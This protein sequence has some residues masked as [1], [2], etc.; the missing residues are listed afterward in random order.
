MNLIRNLDLNALQNEE[1]F[2]IQTDFK[3]EVIKA[4][5]ESLSIG[6]L[7]AAYLLLYADEDAAT[8]LIK[9]SSFT[10]LVAN[11]DFRRDMVSTGLRSLVKVFTNHFD[12]AKQQ[13]AKNM[14]VVFE[15]YG[16]IIDMPYKKQTGATTNLLNELNTNHAAG[17]SLFHLDEY[18]AQLAIENT[19]VNDLMSDRFDEAAAKPL[20]RM[21]EV[22]AEIDVVYKKIIERINAGIIFNGPAAYEGFVRKMNEIIDYNANVIA[23]RKGRAAAGGE[24]NEGG[25][26]NGETGTGEGGEINPLPLP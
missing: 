20:L 9:K 2:Q 3:K 8:E 6:E 19:T 11:A 15:H 13:V 14:W 18:V 10:E 7:F 4:T 22:R 1:H 16:N 12:P 26:E 23:Q 25:T 21:K 17:I 24:S 5:P